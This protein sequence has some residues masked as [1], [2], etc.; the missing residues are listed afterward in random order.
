M[1]QKDGVVN[2]TRDGTFSVDKNNFLVTSEG[3]QVLGYP[4]VAGVITPGVG[5][6]ALQLGAGTISPPLATS[7]VQLTTNVDASAAVGDT[8]STPVTI[9]DSLGASH[10][11]T[12]TF[13][14]TGANAWSYALSLPPGEFTPA[15]GDPAGQVATGSLTFDGSGNL[16]SPTADVAGITIPTLT[17]GANDLSF[18]WKLFD[19]TNS[20]L[21]QVAGPSSTSATQQDGGSSGA[22]VNFSIGADGEVSGSFSNGKTASLGK[23]R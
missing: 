19:G 20:L 7:S 21:T 6:S 10:V 17:N 16:T 5:L 13:T 1:V 11:L 2:Y 9:F 15:A 22:L 8:F 3:Q 14:K 12:F 4:A 18:T 23:S